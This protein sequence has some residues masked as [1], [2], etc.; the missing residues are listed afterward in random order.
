[1][2]HGVC[3]ALNHQ[4][5]TSLNFFRQAFANDQA[6]IDAPPSA[7][8]PWFRWLFVG[9][10]A[11]FVFDYKSPD[12]EFGATGTGGSL[13]QYAFLGVALLTGG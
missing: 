6:E 9:F 1:M 13:F 12:L 11:S 5:S 4:R 2:G 7:A 8:L 10:L 3:P